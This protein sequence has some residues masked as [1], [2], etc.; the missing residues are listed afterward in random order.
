MTTVRVILTTHRPKSNGSRLISFILINQTINE[1]IPLKMKVKNVPDLSKVFF[2][3]LIN[4]TIN[5]YI[6]LKM[7]VKKC[8][9]TWVKS[10]RFFILINQTING[11][12]PLKRKVKNVPGLE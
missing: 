10:F 4:Q 9:R 2:F 8:S 3:I 11:Y 7:K 1:Y 12:I 6:P 5:G